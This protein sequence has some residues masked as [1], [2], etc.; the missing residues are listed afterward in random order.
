ML[1]WIGERVPSFL[2]TYSS[3]GSTILKAIVT[4]RPEIA[5]DVTSLRIAALRQSFLATGKSPA[6]AQSLA[7]SAFDVFQDWRNKVE[8]FDGTIEVLNRIKERYRIVS[9][10][11][12]N[13]EVLK[14][15][16]AGYFELDL[17]AASVGAKKPDPRM[18]VAALEA[19]SVSPS[20]AIHV[21]DH[22]EDDVAGAINVGMQA[23]Q[24]D[25]GTREV[26]PL[27][28]AIVTDLMQL[29]AV[30]ERISN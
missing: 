9:L 13:A 28:T 6:M 10:T 18:F 25:L 14:T 12:G 7:Q 22:P 27:A 3:Q 30:I 19:V 11:N 26:S 5:H 2:E 1:R 17:N 24:L 16:L 21:G 4:E 20:E 29:P 8:L 23:I 15:P